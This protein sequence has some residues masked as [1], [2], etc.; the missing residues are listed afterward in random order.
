[1][2]FGTSFLFDLKIDSVYFLFV[3]FATLSSYSLHWYFTEIKSD[4]YIDSK[5]QFRNHY[6]I[7]HR[8]LL[9]SQFLIAS[10]TCIY[11]LYLQK[12]MIAFAI[13][14]IIA[15]FIYSAPKFP[16]R[17]LKNL[18]GK[19][20]AKTFYLAAVW[21]YVTSVI[22]FLLSNTKWTSEI[23]IF[24]LANFTFLYV[25]CLLFDYRDQHKDQIKFILIDTNLYFNKIIYTLTCIFGLF[26]IAMIYL[27]GS[28][29]IMI[30]LMAS[31]IFMLVTLKKS[32]QTKSDYWFYF[33]LDGLMALPS[34]LGVIIQYVLN[35]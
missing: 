14:A 29:G 6:T 35:N 28:I 1:M 2:S 26:I 19:A 27:K 8:K 32:T 21:I 13:P 11:L 24:Q 20:L 25:I 10:V 18:E 17:A 23:I 22:P 16:I 12:E 5:D 31:F 7:H 9:F 4:K 3:F 30:G 34:L 33:V 15:T